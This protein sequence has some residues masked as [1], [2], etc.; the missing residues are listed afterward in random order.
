MDFAPSPRA[1]DLT[2]RVR[3][4]METEI[5]PAEAGYHRELAALRDGGGDPWTPLPLIAELQGKARAQ[6]LWNLFLPKE[7]AG[8]Y[9]SLIHI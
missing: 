2:Q 7:H 3:T 6:G 5:D 4:F 9:L 8:E 1:A